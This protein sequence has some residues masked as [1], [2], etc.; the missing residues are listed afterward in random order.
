MV[1]DSKFQSQLIPSV[2]TQGF[3]IHRLAYQSLGVIYGDIGTSPL[4][5]YSSTFSSEPSYEDILGAVSFVIWALTIMVTIKY[6]CI[7]LNADD[8]GEGGTFAIYSL[9]SRYVCD[10]GI[11]LES[12]TNMLESHL[13]K[14][15]STRPSPHQSPQNAAA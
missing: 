13:G 15:R 6:V 4:Y 10:A 2:L 11:S 12:S 8:E 7:V 14:T 1:G 5:V 3:T 9:L